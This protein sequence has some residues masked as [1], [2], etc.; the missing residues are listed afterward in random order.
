[1]KDRRNE[2]MCI[3]ARVVISLL[4]LCAM[5]VISPVS[6][7]AQE[8]HV[9]TP[10]TADTLG[11]AGEQLEESTQALYTYLREGILQIADGTRVSATF[12]IDQATLESWGL[13][14]TWTK[15]ELS[16]DNITDMEAVNAAF[17]LQFQIHLLP[18]AL[19][20]DLP[21]EMHWYDKSMGVSY[22]CGYSRTGYQTD[23]DTQVNSVSFTK[24]VIAFSVCADYRPADY[25][26]EAPALD[27]IAIARAKSAAAYAKEIV[28]TYA[29]YSD[30][31]KLL[32]YRNIICDLTDY[33][34]DAVSAT[35]ASGYGD[36][37]QLVYVFD[38]D[39]TTKVVCEGYSKAFQYLCNLSEFDGDVT[40]YTVAGSM[41]GGT[42][43]GLHM[44]NVV[45]MGDGKSYLVD[46]TNSDDGTVGFGG[47]LFLAGGTGSLANGYS[48]RIGFQTISF[49]Y[50]ENTVELWGEDAE[51]LLALSQESYHPA[52]IVITIPETLVYTGQALT[53]G[54]E[55]A[56]VLYSCQGGD[57]LTES[58][59]WS[60]SWCSDNNGQLGS[61]LSEAPKNA[62]TYWVR[63]LAQSKTNYFDIQTK[64]VQVTVERAVPQYTQ[65]T[66]LLATYGDMLST[67]VLPEGFAWQDDAG[68]TMVG[69]AGI[70]S[71]LVTYTPA[72]TQNYQTVTDISVEI[73]VAKATPV[74]Q[75]PEGL[76]AQYGDRLADVMLPSGF[77]W[78]NDETTVVDTVG[79]QS[80]KLSYNPDP[81]NYLTATDIEVPLT[82]TRRDITN[83][84]IVLGAMPSYNGAMQTQAIVSVTANGVPVTTYL[85]NGNTA[86]EIGT[87]TMTVT[88]EGNFTGAVTAVWRISPDLSEIEG[89]TVDN[90][91]S[92]DIEA[93]N[94]VCLAVADQTE[95]FRDLLTHC[96]V[97]LSR[98]R[99]VMD[100]T[101]SIVEDTTVVEGKSKETLVALSDRADA[102]INGEN[103]TDE[104]RASVL[105]AK[106]RVDEE[107]AKLQEAE[108]AAHKEETEETLETV[109]IYIGIAVA[110][111]VLVLV[112]IV[113]VAV[114]KKE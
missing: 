68:A 93:I 101:A 31:E 55:N 111:A 108:D 51:S 53:A 72:D 69:N 22:Q 37:W 96:E 110:A 60:V 7:M 25:D 8:P 20:H 83:A 27:P 109:A 104:E 47:E 79:T 41:A 91:K 30:Y 33:N 114:K 10:Q 112:V 102:L 76:T 45:V 21:Y 66:S 14:V 84:V 71:F 86:T 46:I 85:V 81:Q 103:L 57:S 42:G 35:Y 61:K 15:E 92:K 56:D 59:N 1:M 24:L 34:D 82:V 97:M 50:D 26:P 90:V 40:C 106:A 5:L 3:C 88:G 113:L 78:Q 77:A 105:A 18:E 107:L 12:E 2:R 29:S 99:T 32:A 4:L 65:P 48:V 67:V 87:Y 28:D 52:E 49:V 95:A 70:N 11:T 62:G 38:K 75:I 6:V 98:L 16:V 63:V 74:Y 73:T 80:Y 17:F 94:R 58:Y 54:L 19:T 64:T 36:P 39:D 100:E 13:K 23:H 43:A 9:A 89:L 44:W